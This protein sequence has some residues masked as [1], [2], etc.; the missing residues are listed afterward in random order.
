MFTH[1][2]Q[3]PQ[4]LASDADAE[5]IEM[6]MEREMEE[7]VDMDM[8][9]LDLDIKREMTEKEMTEFTGNFID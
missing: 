8:Y 7:Q 4:V 9:A 1:R 3:S 5:N 2:E 6:E